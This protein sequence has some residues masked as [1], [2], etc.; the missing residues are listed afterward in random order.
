MA[1]R[2]ER[3]KPTNQPELKPGVRVKHVDYGDRFGVIEDIL[4]SA[5]GSKSYRV[6][7][8]PYSGNAYSKTTTVSATVLEMEAAQA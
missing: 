8:F 1:M 5:S 6:H 7:W 3:L 2:K 4:T